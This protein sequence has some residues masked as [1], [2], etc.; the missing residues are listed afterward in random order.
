MKADIELI[1][2][3][4]ELLSG[5]TL[6]SHAQTLGAALSAIGLRLSRDTTVPDEIETIQ[7]AVREALARTDIVIASGGLGPTSDDITRDALA[8]L[9]SRKIVMSPEGLAALHKRFATR[10]FTVTPASERMALILEG[11]ESLVNTAGAAVAQRIFPMVGK[12]LFIVP[13]PP[14]EFA[15]ILNDHI[16]PWLCD[17]FPEATPLELRVL[18]TQGIGESDIVT[19]L[20]A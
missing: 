11:A 19:R 6:N 9:F 13:G 15:A 3:G 1:S 5:R 4:S 2:I 20:E 14:N 8:E 16:V 18:T 7:S 10:D 12:V 17:Q